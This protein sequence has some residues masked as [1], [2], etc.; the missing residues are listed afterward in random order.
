MALLANSSSEEMTTA[1]SPDRPGLRSVRD[2]AKF[3]GVSVSQ[4]YLMCDRGELDLVKIG[5]R[6]TR[7]TQA[8]LDAFVRNAPRVAPHH[9][10]KRDDD[11]D[12][13]NDDA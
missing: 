2:A 7:I 13:G 5:L 1:G 12:D 11:N 4:I 8:S 10:R 3:L 9:R 6:G